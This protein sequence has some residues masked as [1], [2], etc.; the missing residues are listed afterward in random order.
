ML[1]DSMF[2]SRGHSTALLGN[3]ARKSSSPAPSSRSLRR[4]TGASAF[5][6]TECVKHLSLLISR[7][8][9]TAHLHVRLSRPLGHTSKHHGCTYSPFSVA[10]CG[11]FCARLSDPELLLD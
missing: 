9:R 6:L 2:A 11:I 3:D 1:N 7:R 10:H 5:K 8:K 4:T